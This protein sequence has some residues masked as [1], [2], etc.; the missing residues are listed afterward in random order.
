MAGVDKRLSNETFICAL[1][2]D[3]RNLYCLPFLHHLRRKPLAA[4]NRRYAPTRGENRGLG[5]VRIVAHPKP[6][7]LPRL[8]VLPDHAT[9][10]LGELSCP[11]DDRLQNGLEIQG[12]TECAPHVTEG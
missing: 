4:G 8:V 6:E 2:R 11:R 9:G 3:I 12:R 10:R 5:G 7:F 1:D